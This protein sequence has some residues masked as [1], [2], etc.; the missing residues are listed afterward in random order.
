MANFSLDYLSC[1]SEINLVS[2]LT[3]SSGTTDF[4]AASQMQKV[5]LYKKLQI[6]ANLY[7]LVDAA[8]CCTCHETSFY[9]SFTTFL[10]DKRELLVVSASTNVFQVPSLAATFKSA[11]WLEREL[12]D[13][14]GLS[15]KGLTDTRS[16]LLDY[17]DVKSQQ[18]THKLGATNYSPINYEVVTNY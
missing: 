7:Y 10:T 5:I 15:F 17:L 2:L 1:F 16:L 3:S 13:F 11:V 8:Q 14:T 6:P 18:V 12:S 9:Y 4:I